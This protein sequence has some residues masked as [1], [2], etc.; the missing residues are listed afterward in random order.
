[1]KQV[2]QTGGFME[3]LITVEKVVIDLKSG[4]RTEMRATV[5]SQKDSTHQRI[6]LTYEGYISEWT[7]VK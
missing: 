7:E 5:S 6:S 4:K 1:M 3:N 2:N